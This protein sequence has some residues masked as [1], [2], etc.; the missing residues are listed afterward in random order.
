MVEREVAVLRV[1]RN[2]GIGQPPQAAVSLAH[3]R[4]EALEAR[5]AER[6]LVHEQKI[7]APETL[8]GDRAV[9]LGIDRD[10]VLA[11]RIID[12]AELKNTVSNRH[13]FRSWL[14]KELISLPKIHEELVNEGSLEL[15]A[16]PDTAP[17]RGCDAEGIRLFI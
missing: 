7:A 2:L 17:I 9:G 1:L 4:A 13:D 12:D 15:A 16:K 3:D 6:G 8:A 10:P 5:T 11:G 14:Q